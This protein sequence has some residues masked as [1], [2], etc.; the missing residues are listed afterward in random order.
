MRSP[1]GGLCL[2]N[3]VLVEGEPGQP[4]VDVAC[5][6]LRSL[7]FFWGVL[8]LVHFHCSIADAC[9]MFGDGVIPY[10]VEER[11]LFNNFTAFRNSLFDEH[12]R[13]TLKFTTQ[14]HVKLVRLVISTHM[15]VFA[16]TTS[17]PVFSFRLS[18]TPS[19]IPIPSF[20]RPLAEHTTFLV[21][22]QPKAC[23]RSSWS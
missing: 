1:L 17:S 3:N 2:G 15:A 18:A 11:V 8:H 4:F 7:G 21:A 16:C 9:R 14:T 12:G 22:S 6:S 13:K 10:L 5:F 23:G 20:P 19:P